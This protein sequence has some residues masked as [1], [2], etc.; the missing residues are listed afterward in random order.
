MAAINHFNLCTLTAHYVTIPNSTTTIPFEV[1]TTAPQSASS[2]PATVPRY[3]ATPR[4]LGSVPA[5]DKATREESKKNSI[6]DTAVALG[7]WPT[8]TV[9]VSAATAPPSATTATES[10]SKYANP[11]VR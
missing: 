1:L 11:A 4:T 7:F 9:P 8:S 3:E 6:L 5:C 2:V 10:W